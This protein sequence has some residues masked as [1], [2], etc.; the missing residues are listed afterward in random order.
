VA[1]S[2][3]LQA[4]AVLRAVRAAIGEVNELLPSDQQLATDPDLPLAGNAR[5]LDSL[6]AVNL[7]VSAEAAVREHTGHSVDLAGAL[8][9]PGDE[10][11]FRTMRALA[12]WIEAQLRDRHG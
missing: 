2:G 12:A 1:D 9:I 3:T 11:P 10:S 4:D 6:M 5:R 8:A 7:M